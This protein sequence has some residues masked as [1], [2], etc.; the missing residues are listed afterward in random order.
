MTKSREFYGA[1]PRW[2]FFAALGCAVGLEAAVVA[3][4]GRQAEP[5]IPGEIDHPPE[6]AIVGVVITPPEEILPPESLPPIPP[7]RPQPRDEFVTIQPPVPSHSSKKLIRPA[8]VERSTPVMAGAVN[9]LSG[10]DKM[11]FAP[12]PTYPYEARRSK[13][14]G[15]GRYLLTFAPDG[16]VLTVSLLQRT[17][18]PLL[19][20]A[21]IR[22][23]MRWRCKPG[24]YKQVCVPV[25]FALRGEDW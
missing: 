24:V 17:G 1:T 18:R 2:R 4:A 7:P 25:T 15:T 5:G 11:I 23:L 16:T 22:T 8:S 13:Q 9:S 21:A 10:K 20:Q 6:S 19:D 3:L 12:H 14:A